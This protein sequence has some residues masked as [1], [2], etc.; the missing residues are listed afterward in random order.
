MLNA[1]NQN[2]TTICAMLL[3]LLTRA[4]AAAYSTPRYPVSYDPDDTR[5]SLRTARQHCACPPL[6]HRRDA[7]SMPE[8]EPRT[9]WTPPVGYD[10]SARRSP[11]R[12]T[13]GSALHLSSL[14]RKHD[15][16]EIAW[17][18]TQRN[19]GDGQTT[20]CTGIWMG[21]KILFKTCVDIQRDV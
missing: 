8:L 2:A 14:Y 10:P 18:P 13:H 16:E 11:P 3:L 17:D 5:P 12:A 7:A 1:L 15:V 20:L 21:K 19:D 6:P 9:P 4:T